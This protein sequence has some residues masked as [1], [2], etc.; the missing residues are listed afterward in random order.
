LH[1]PEC[2]SC[3]GH[4]EGGLGGDVRRPV[5]YIFDD[6]DNAAVVVLDVHDPIEGV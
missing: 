5:A 1:A 6:A 3:Q 2:L 4:P